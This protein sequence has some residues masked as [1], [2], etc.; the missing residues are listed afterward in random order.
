MKDVKMYIWNEKVERL[1]KQFL[2]TIV[3]ETN[4]SRF[5]GE[6]GRLTSRET[7]CTEVT[8]FV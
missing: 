5:I 7:F 8:N 2:I 4:L 3:M 1:W 6:K